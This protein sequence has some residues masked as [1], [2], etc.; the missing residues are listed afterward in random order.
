MNNR[1]TWTDFLAA[2]KEDWKQEFL[3]ATK[4]NFK[5]WQTNEGFYLEPLY[6]KGDVKNVA[7]A[8]S[9]NWKVIELIE[10]Q[11]I[12]ELNQ[13]V[14][15]AL[16]QGVEGIEFNY[17]SAN[18]SDI[19]AILNNVICPIINIDIRD[20][21]HPLSTLESLDA[22]S[23]RDYNGNSQFQGSVIFDP[24]DQLEKSGNAEE[25][26]NNLATWLEL[27]LHSTGRNGMLRTACIDTNLAHNAGANASI[28]LAIALAKG[29][30]LLFQLL[31]NNIKIDEAA[32]LF[33]FRMG[34]GTSFFIEMAKFRAIR[35][36]WNQIIEQYSPEF[37]CSANMRLHAQSATWNLSFSDPETNLLRLTSESMSA[38][39]GGVNSLALK[40]NRLQSGNSA[41][42]TK[43]IARNI[44]YLLKEES[45][46]HKVADPASG[47]PY[48]E[49]ITAELIQSSWEIF[50]EIEN[51]GGYIAVVK[52]DWLKSKMD[53]SALHLKTQI[54]SGTK[55]WLGVNKYAP[56]HSDN[57]VNQSK[58]QYSFLY[59]ELNLESEFSAKK[60]T[61]K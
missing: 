61:E 56:H 55:T 16:E 37:P 40:T 15:N 57:F 30:E 18:K 34:I 60:E 32:A 46:A 11:E 29:H 53:S 52:N 27:A 36:L 58:N 49:K 54:I 17:N 31:S 25:L 42:F 26:N 39:Y 20:Q 24:F 59:P 14:L 28:E 35:V 44:Q 23:G 48:I 4:G 13:A 45:F 9:A 1:L 7:V 22:L 2:S 3:K 6:F 19:H 12:E 21:L 5:P 33:Q 41:E 38:V 51:Q 43:R 47:A 50:R 8:L 10:G